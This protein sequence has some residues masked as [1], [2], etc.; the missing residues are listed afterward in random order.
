MDTS[1]LNNA[2]KMRIKGVTLTHAKI[3]SSLKAMQ[4]WKVDKDGAVTKSGKPVSAFYFTMFSGPI[5]FKNKLIIIDG[6]EATQKQLKK[7]S[8]DKI[9]TINPVNPNNAF[10]H[11]ADTLVAKYGDKAKM[12]VVY[13][14]TKR[15]KPT[16]ACLSSIKPNG[17]TQ[18][19]GY[20][21]TACPL[22]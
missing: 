4:G 6:K 14:T 19:T 15:I 10:N 1:K 12:G 21:Y 22:G 8:I 16:I 11:K 18:H 17:Q 3:D 2:T 9:A 5:D 20:F 7:L 13:I